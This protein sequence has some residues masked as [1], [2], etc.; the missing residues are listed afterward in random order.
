[1]QEIEAEEAGLLQHIGVESIH[2]DEL[3]RQAEMP[4]ANVRSTLSPL[5]IKGLVKAGR[6]NPLCTCAGNRSELPTG[7]LEELWRKNS[8]S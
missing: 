4:V 6:R 7:K 1:M 3:R 5:Q 2:I 8:L